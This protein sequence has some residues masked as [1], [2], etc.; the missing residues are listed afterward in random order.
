MFALIVAG[1]FP[2]IL[3]SICAVLKVDTGLLLTIYNTNMETLL[4]FLSNFQFSD[5]HNL[6]IPSNG[7]NIF[8]CGF[9]SFYLIEQYLR[10]RKHRAFAHGLPTQLK[11]RITTDEYIETTE[12]NKAK[13]CFGFFDDLQ[14]VVTTFICLFVFWPVTWEIV[15][16]RFGDYSYA[17][18]FVV[19]AAFTCMNEIIEFCLKGPMKAYYTFVVD[20]KFNNM[21]PVKYLWHKVKSLLI[22]LVLN[23]IF[24]FGLVSIIDWAGPDAWKWMI[25]FVILVVIIVQVLFP[26]TVAKCFNT[27]TP[28]PE[29]QLKVAID[30]LV[31]KTNLDCKQCYMVDGSTQ[32]SHSNAYVAGMCGTRRIVI[33]DTLV[34]DLQNDQ[35]R[36]KAVVGH[37]IGHAKLNHNW[38]LTGV[39]AMMFS[40]MFY[41]FSF[42]QSNAEMVES[43][44]FTSHSGKKPTTFLILHCFMAV[45]SSCFMP[46]MS[47]MVNGIV[48]QLEF[49]ADRYAVSLGY[50]IRLALLDLSKENLGDLNPDPWYSSYHYTH[51][52][53][54]SRLEAVTAQMGGA[55]MPKDVVTQYIKM[56][57]TESTE[58]TMDDT[59]E[60]SK[61]NDGINEKSDNSISEDELPPPE[62][63]MKP[64][65]DEPPPTGI[66][67]KI[68]TI[69][70]ASEKNKN[71]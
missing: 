25:G 69:E 47:V 67:A 19:P 35:P 51:P 40:S 6:F 42:F 62:V 44:G 14:S 1:A 59:K 24:M 20:S 18:T 38:I 58:D 70:M 48:R 31:S 33:Y 29:G 21:T 54:V 11:G 22:G 13:N 71:A 36:I 9:V 57:G 49:A 64:P 7:R 3:A 68:G 50:D 43:F 15:Q 65:S 53:L 46:F 27:F 10:Y 16:E 8:L 30:D 45:Y 32:S 5:I 26:V 56:P 17:D 60:E 2:V 63:V 41:L 4:N 66:A 61:K 55:P 39:N 12:H 23:S 28:L 34:K 37:E 52:D